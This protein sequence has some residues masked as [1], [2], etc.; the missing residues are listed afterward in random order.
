MKRWCKSDKN[1]S[2]RHTKHAW[3]FAQACNILGSEG[4]YNFP[5]V[6]VTAVYGVDDTEKLKALVAE[7]DAVICGSS[8]LKYNKQIRELKNIFHMP[9]K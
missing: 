5:D 7:H 9:W 8:R 3:A 4:N 2:Y 6:R 1:R